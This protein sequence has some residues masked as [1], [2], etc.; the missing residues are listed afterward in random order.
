M[1]N[2]SIG[3]EDFPLELLAAI[4][5]AVWEFGDLWSM[6]RASRRLYDGVLLSRRWRVVNEVTTTVSG[7]ERHARLLFGRPLCLVHA[8]SIGNIR[9]LRFL[10][11]DR[12]EAHICLPL[13]CAEGHVECLHYLWMEIGAT[14]A[15]KEWQQEYSDAMCD[16]WEG[17]DDDRMIFLASLDEHVG[18]GNWNAP[19]SLCG[20]LQLACFGGHL[21]AVE[22]LHEHADIEVEHVCAHD[23]W[24]IISAC[25]NGHLPVVQYLHS[26]FPTILHNTHRNDDV[27]GGCASR[28]VL[29][30]CTGGH[31]D[32]LVFL[33]SIGVRDVRANNNE[34]LLW[35]CRNGHLEI[36]RYLHEELGIDIDDIRSTNLDD[37]GDG[38]PGALSWSCREG[39]LSVV[40]YLHEECGLTDADV[41]ARDVDALRYAC[42][43]GGPMDLI[44]YLHTEFGLTATDA[45]VLDNR[46]LAWACVAGHMDVVKYLHAEMGLTRE[47]A[48]ACGARDSALAGG[49]MDI[50][51]YL[52]TVM[53]STSGD[54]VSQALL[55]PARQVRTAGKQ[56]KGSRRPG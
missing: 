44:Q 47:D 55:P 12:E 10:M 9:L 38:Q 53:N 6:L 20:T 11:P 27:D 49:H 52:D 54:A 24:A 2:K 36:I 16:T 13:V 25:E 21:R 30:A 4:A 26:R 1:S 14:G 22:Y 50:A 41:R 29:A 3:L 28:A 40:K 56:E 37:S 31:R 23:A 42:V 8:S 32:V 5:D 15:E 33:T 48:R 34:S 46:M 17:T 51:R 39:H 45:R 19:F 43:F 18:H 7:V 35:A